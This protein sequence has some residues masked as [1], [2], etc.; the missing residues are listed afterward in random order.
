MDPIQHLYQ[1]VQYE[2]MKYTQFSTLVTTTTDDIQ[3]AYS[4]IAA[5][6][7]STV[8]G[9]T[10]TVQQMISTNLGTM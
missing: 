6:H 9:L 2:R 3:N 1:Y 8:T 10:V 5:V 7:L 4:T